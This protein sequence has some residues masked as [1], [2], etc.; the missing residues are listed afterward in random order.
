M[1]Q[2]VK[3]TPMKSSI[4][5]LVAGIGF[6]LLSF[7]ASHRVPSEPSATSAYQLDKSVEDVTSEDVAMLRKEIESI[8]RERKNLEKRTEELSK[9]MAQV[10]SQT[11]AMSQN[12]VAAEPQLNPTE[13]LEHTATRM[14]AQVEL[15]E[16][17]LRTEIVDPQWTGAAEVA[18][19]ETF[20]KENMKGFQLRAVT[21][22]TTLCRME[23]TLEGLSPPEGSFAK[24]AHSMPWQGQGFVRINS[25]ETAG[26]ALYLSREG[27]SLPRLPN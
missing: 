15:V 21:C 9:E 12:Q 20:H 25:E 13:E 1:E 5:G 14:Q 11:E 26:I 7:H 4:L 23:L 2:K 17:T 16:G 22:R 8:K 3:S 24:L 6:A 27:Y 10:R 18:L 19:R